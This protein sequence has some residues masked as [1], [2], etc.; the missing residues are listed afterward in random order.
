MNQPPEYASQTHSRLKDDSQSGAYPL[1][2]PATGVVLM[3]EMETPRTSACSSSRFLFCATIE[4]G[5]RMPTDR[6]KGH[7]LERK[8]A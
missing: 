8:R 4:A 5:I 6:Y 2:S 7:V 1:P 3:D